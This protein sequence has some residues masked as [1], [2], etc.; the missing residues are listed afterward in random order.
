MSSCVGDCENVSQWMAAVVGVKCACEVR[1]AP[2]SRKRKASGRREGEKEREKPNELS[3]SAFADIFYL[4]VFIPLI[5]AK[6]SR[7]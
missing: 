2:T 6:M 5:R 4:P 3:P 7:C 1:V